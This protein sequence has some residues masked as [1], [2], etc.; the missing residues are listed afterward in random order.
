MSSATSVPLPTLS[1]AEL[2]RYSRN[3]L[4]PGFGVDAQRKLQ[5][6][7]VLVIGAGGL[8]SPAA[9][10]LAAAGVGTIG[11]AEFDRVEAHNLQRQILHDTAAIGQPKLHTALARLQALNPHIAIE[12]HAAGIVPANALEIFARYDVVVDGTDNFPARYLNNDAAVLTGRPLVYGSIFQ[13]EGQITV[14]APSRGGPC[15]RCLFPEPPPPG[16]VPN[17]GEAGVIGALCGTIGSLQAMEAIKLLAGVGKPT[18]GRLIVHDALTAAFRTLNIRRDP[19]CPVCGENPRLRAIVAE[20]YTF[21]CAPT[22]PAPTPPA[23]EQHGE[24]PL[25]VDVVSAADLHGRGATLLDV[26]EPFEH[27]IGTV[28]GSILMP[29]RQVPESIAELPRHVPLLVLC[30]HGGRSLR[31]TQY[32]RQHGFGN[33]VNVRGG[34]DAWSREIDSRIPRY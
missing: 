2:V 29:M 22:P 19:A 7:R 16:S 10:Y 32:L 11:L 3:I 28:P 13:F 4:L 30:H 23:G 15:Y 25:E 26:R 9:L 17:C 6:G 31:V 14:F 24:L 18:I 34:I 5:R 21:G 20:N 1:S 33:A 27:A 8:G 12:P